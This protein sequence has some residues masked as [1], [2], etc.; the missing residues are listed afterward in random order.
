M[1][2]LPISILQRI[3]PIIEV[4]LSISILANVVDYRLPLN[5]SHLHNVKGSQIV[6]Q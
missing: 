3:H 1:G 2:V 6:S 4:T 5:K